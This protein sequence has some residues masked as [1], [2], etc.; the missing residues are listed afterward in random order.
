MLRGGTVRLVDGENQ[1]LGVVPVAEALAK[2][3]ESGLDLVLVADKA[4]PP[5]CRLMNFG[6]YQYEKNRR[7]REQR[8]K[9]V[10]NKVKEVKFHANID[11]HDLEIKTHHILEF[12]QKGYRVK[13]SLVMR[14]REVTHKE[15]GLG[16]VQRVVAAVSTHGVVEMDA[17]QMGRIVS[18]QLA[19]RTGKPSA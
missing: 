1:Q 13:V 19:P 4:E 9:Q 2:A 15:I 16:L 6:K 18:L 10:V 8:K 5:V 7:E 17:R 11:V 12:L 14:G 3:Q